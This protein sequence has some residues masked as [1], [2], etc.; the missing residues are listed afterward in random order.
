MPEEPSLR[1][2]VT[3]NIPAKLDAV[4]LPLLKAPGRFTCASCRRVGG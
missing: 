1:E 4:A 3:S 2:R